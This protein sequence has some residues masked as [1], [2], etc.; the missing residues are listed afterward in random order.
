M[1]VENNVH[2]RP[3]VKIADGSGAKSAG[4]PGKPGP[5]RPAPGNANSTVRALPPVK[6]DPPNPKRALSME[7]DA[8]LADTRIGK[9]TAGETRIANGIGNVV[10]SLTGKNLRVT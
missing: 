9:F 8:G 7:I 10:R 2:H 3:P 6:P 5:A 4:A 1:S